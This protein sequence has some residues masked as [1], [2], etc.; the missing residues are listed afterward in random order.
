MVSRIQPITPTLRYRTVSDFADVT[1]DKP[2]KSLLES[3]G[4]TASNKSPSDLA[5]KGGGH[6]RLYRSSIQTQKHGFRRGVS[7][8]YDPKRPR[9]SRSCIMRGEKTYIIAPTTSR[10]RHG[11][12]PAEAD[13]SGMRLLEKIPGYHGAQRALSPQGRTDGALGGSFAQLM[14]RT[15]TTPPATSVGEMRMVRKECY[16]SVRQVGNLDPRESGVGKAGRSRWMQTPR[17]RG[18]P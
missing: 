3:A 14:R 4:K 13:I 16:A 1:T 7:V 18:V 11:C 2:E 6:K 17:V 10:S 5:A 8:E 12:W 15:A 9:A